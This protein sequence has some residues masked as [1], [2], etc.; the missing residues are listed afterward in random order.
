M[1]E[2]LLFV[3]YRREDTSP[4]ALALKAEL[5][6]RLVSTLVFVDVLRINTA[7]T[8]PEVL[9]DAL[10]RAQAM[11]VLIG[12]G[13]MEAVDSKGRSKLFDKDDWVRKEIV[14]AL[15]NTDTTVIPILV[16]NAQIPDP[17]HLPDE[18][19]PLFD[20]E[21]LRLDPKNWHRDLSELSNALASKLG[22]DGQAIEL[23]WPEPDPLKKEVPLT[24]KET[25]EK[26]RSEG[27]LKNWKVELEHDYAGDG[28]FAEQL[29]LKLRFESFKESIRFIN[30]FS[31]ECE[32]ENHHPIWENTH[33]NLTIKFRTFDA[34]HRISHFD[35]KM[36]E[37]VNEA[38]RNYEKKIL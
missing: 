15:V 20:I 9:T 33:R 36:A 16:E 2:T 31:V 3:S 6:K 37:K 18:I 12:T 21:A 26:L 24:T 38:L 32:N 14:S 5:E 30:E 25:F 19:A 29:V 27:L 13:W 7:D 10:E 17:D 8:W 34:G 23:P 11:L 4:Y 35:L 22:L 28:T 1:L